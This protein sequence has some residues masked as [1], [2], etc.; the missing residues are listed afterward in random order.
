MTT[1]TKH[2]VTKTYTD[3]GLATGKQIFLSNISS[4]DI[5]LFI[6]TTATTSDTGIY[7]KQK[8]NLTVQLETGEFLFARVY[9][10]NGIGSLVSVIAQ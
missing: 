9:D 8:T 3:L 4:E 7:F 10:K 1:T 5:E 6:G 2:D